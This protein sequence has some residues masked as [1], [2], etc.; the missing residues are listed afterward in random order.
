MQRQ[1]RNLQLDKL[2]KVVEL[3]RYL[4][5]LF[6]L[7]IVW[8]CLFLLHNRWISNIIRFSKKDEVHLHSTLLLIKM[9]NS[10]GLERWLLLQRTQVWFQAPTRCLATTRNS[11]GIQHI[12]LTSAN[13]AR[14][15]QTYIPSGN[16]FIHIR[17]NIWTDL[18][19]Y[20]ITD[21]GRAVFHQL[22]SQGNAHIIWHI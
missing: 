17:K 12:L 14:L 16:T 7:I 8:V 15:M 6:R 1:N 19:E 3:L 11:K 4:F 18:W 10:L 13:M 9:M 21:S 2:G 5:V 20:N 22:P